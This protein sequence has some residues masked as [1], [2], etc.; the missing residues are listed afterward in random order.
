MFLA[1]R[2]KESSSDDATV[3][4]VVLVLRPT[5]ILMASVPSW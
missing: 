3:R 1:E 4:A 2:M 5:T